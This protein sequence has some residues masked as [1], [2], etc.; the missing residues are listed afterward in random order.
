MALD[1]RPKTAKK[2]GVLKPMLLFFFFKQPENSVI[3]YKILN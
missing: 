2:G 3:I 1:I